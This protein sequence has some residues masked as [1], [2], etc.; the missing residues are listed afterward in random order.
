MYSETSLSVNLSYLP[1]VPSATV[2]LEQFCTHPT[3]S[4]HYTIL[5]PHTFIQF[6][7]YYLQFHPEWMHANESSLKCKKDLSVSHKMGGRRNLYNNMHAHTQPPSVWG[8]LEQQGIMLAMQS[9]HC[10]YYTCKDRVYSSMHHLLQ[11]GDVF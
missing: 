7:H 1:H 11:E 9:R 4:E 2:L 8:T 3:D 5:L 6:P 10:W